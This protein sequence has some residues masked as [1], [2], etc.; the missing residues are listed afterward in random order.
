[1][2][3]QALRR[4][5]DDAALLY[6]LALSLVRQQQNAKALE[7][8]A[9]AARADAANARY[10]YG[11]AIALNDDGHTAAAIET[12]ERAVKTHPDDRD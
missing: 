12:P 11:Y 3:R 10:S 7:L 5:P 8:F 9:Q 1:V 2:F 6:A 4:S